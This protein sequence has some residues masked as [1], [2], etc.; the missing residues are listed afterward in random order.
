MKRLISTCEW[1]R[2]VVSHCIYTVSVD[3]VGVWT[4]PLDSSSV[5]LCSYFGTV[6]DST[7]V[8]M[9]DRMTLM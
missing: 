4:L 3:A 7:V 8:V 1:M 5:S 6:N 2:S 9:S